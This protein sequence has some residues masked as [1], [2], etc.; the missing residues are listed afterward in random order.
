MFSIHKRITLII[1]LML[2]TTSIALAQNKKTVYLDKNAPIEERVKDLLSR[3]TLEEKAGQLNQLNYGMFTGPDNKVDGEQEKLDQ[4]KQGKVGSFLNTLGVSKIKKVQQIAVEQS[5][6]KIPLLFGFDVIHGYKTLFPIPLAEACSWD[7]D[8]VFLNSRI[9]A[10]ESAASGL[11]WAFAPMCDISNDPRWGRVMEGAGEDPYYGS[12]IAAA[13]VKGFQGNLESVF[14]ILACVKHFAVYGAVEA[15]REYNNVDVSRVAFYNKYLPPYE[16][17][18]KAGAAT[19]MTSFNVF[20]GV[21]ASGNSFL[22]TDILQKKLGFKG[23]V[24]SDWNA[25]AEMIAHGYAEDKKDAVY[26]ALK[27]GS[28]M[29]MESRTAIKFLPE[30]VKEGKLTEEEVDKAV[31][32]I[33]YYKFKLGLFENPYKFLDEKREKENVFNAENRKM[34]KEAAEK[35]ILLLKNNNEI[36]PLKNPNQKIALIGF[37][38]NSKTDMVDMWK[39]SADA[40]D[41]VTIYEGLKKQFSNLT[42]TEGYKQDNS[43]SQELLNQAV[44]NAENAEVVI[45]NIGIT[46]NLSGEDKSLADI[47]IPEGQLKL[48]KALKETGKPIVI[49]VSSGRPMILNEVQNLSDALVQCWIL[50]TESGN[51]IAEVLSGKYNPSAKTVMS[52]PYALGQIPVYYNHFNTGRPAPDPNAKE[53]P[54]DFY[55][56]FHDIPNEPL[57]P[58]GYGLS[59]TTFKYSNFKLSAPVMNED[60]FLS[61]TAD[62]QNTGKYD[63]EEVVQLYIQDVTASIVRPVKELKGFKKVL[64]K[65]GEKTTIEFKIKPEDLSFFDQNGKSILEK[66]KFNVYMGG[67]S[68][69]VLAAS[70]ELR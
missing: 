42:F 63:G 64:V 32:S 25:F 8:Q 14:D 55:S 45:V 51:A 21:P 40:Q 30:L 58:F 24:V 33:L 15:G 2:S 48:L 68:R 47:N 60:G 50:G 36:L 66:G 35:S 22:L 26:K 20:D 3:M 49:L 70:F 29:D 41:C 1:V 37:Y 57:Y 31:G 34:A 16:A 4:V 6:L 7:M 69:D 38:A 11:N 19:V 39:A 61:V 67:N 9:A 10:K 54:A 46:S 18:V 65:A 44:K 12:V 5:R 27:A 13:R 17:A 53:K 59:Y 62:L 23:F 43:T 28:M 56:R 52:F